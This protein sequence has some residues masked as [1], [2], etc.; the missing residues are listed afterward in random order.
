MWVA[1]T[2]DCACQS[3]SDSVSPSWACV[4]EACKELAV[5]TKLCDEEK[6]DVTLSVTWEY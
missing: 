6:Q 5:S 3:G 1:F 2:W 4:L